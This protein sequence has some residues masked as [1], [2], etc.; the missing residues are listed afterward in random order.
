MF[1]QLV[2]LIDKI[3]EDSIGEWIID[4][5]N[6][7]TPEH[8]IQM[9]FVVYSRIVRQFED[10]VYNFEEEHPEY[11]LN[12]YGLILENC[13]I[14]WGTESMST[15]DVSKMDAQC[16]MA[17]MMGAVR[18]ERFCDGAL[19]EFFENGSIERWLCRLKEIEEKGESLMP[20]PMSNI[21]LIKGSCADQDVDVVVNAANNGLWA[22]GGICG[23]IFKKAGM[24]ELTDACKKYKTPLKDGDAVIT[25]AFNLK[26]TKAIIHAVGPNF[27][28]TPHA[29]KELF[30][31]YYNSLVVMKENGY[32]SI[33]FPL[34]SSGIFGGSL[35]NPAAESTKQC[36]RAYNKFVEDY[37]SYEVDVKL[38]AFSDREMEE[39]KMVFDDYF[40]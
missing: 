37:P 28:N 25:S 38:C 14:N 15:V 36:C 22:G 12:R 13:G 40:G 24:V 17:L 34:I 27:G 18:A 39:A 6:D 32:H 20:K 11:G 10:A 19:K 31:A 2:G 26:N 7:G 9:P 33:S 1:E 4:K 5:E 30:N 23:V 3:K 29:F 21:E 8:P 16:V 35:D